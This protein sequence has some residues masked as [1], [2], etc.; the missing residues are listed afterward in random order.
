M[1]LPIAAIGK[2]VENAPV[3]LNESF[4][5]SKTSQKRLCGNHEGNA[6][7]T[8]C[9]IRHRYFGV[10]KFFVNEAFQNGTKDIKPASF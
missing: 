1:L 9:T 8:A 7:A 4:L 5:H 2:N 3:I 6:Q 10:K